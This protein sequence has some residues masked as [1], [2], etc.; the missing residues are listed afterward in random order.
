MKISKSIYMQYKYLMIV[1]IKGRT[2]N[3]PPI[4]WLHELISLFQLHEL[5]SLFQ[6]HQSF[7]LFRLHLV[8]LATLHVVMF[9]M[10]GYNP[11]TQMVQYVI[12]KFTFYLGESQTTFMNNLCAFFKIQNPKMKN[13]NLHSFNEPQNS[14][15]FQGKSNHLHEQFAKK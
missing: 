3:R 13:C 5:Y 8:I 2:F 4:F 7:S 1:P 12:T 11:N 6:L 10:K 15:S 9:S 14:H